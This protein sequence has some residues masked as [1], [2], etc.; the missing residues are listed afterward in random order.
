ADAAVEAGHDRA[1]PMPLRF[2]FYLPYEHAEDVALQQRC[3]DLVRPLKNRE[4]YYWA[5]VHADAIYR[6]GRFP[7][8]NALLGRE[9]TAAE[10]VYL[11]SGGFGA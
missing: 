11:E 9:T 4:L 2:F 5:L 6:F 7:H 8:R 1:F 10:K 3:L